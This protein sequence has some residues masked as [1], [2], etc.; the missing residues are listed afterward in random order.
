M[1]IKNV[2]STPKEEGAKKERPYKEYKK[3]EYQEKK[4]EKAVDSD[5]FEEVVSKKNVQREYRP[6]KNY[7]NNNKNRKYDDKRKGQEDE[8]KEKE[9]EN[10]EKPQQVESQPKKEVATL[11]IKSAP[12]SLKDIFA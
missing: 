12:K 4:E 7:Y 5:G 1:E 11:T 2:Y 9:K 3:R 8:V 6:K 10:E